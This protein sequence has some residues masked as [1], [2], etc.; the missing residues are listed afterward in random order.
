MS[1]TR[2]MPVF[3][4]NPEKSVDRFRKRLSHLR[5]QEALLR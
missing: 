1:L 2:P 3:D 4:D 5:N